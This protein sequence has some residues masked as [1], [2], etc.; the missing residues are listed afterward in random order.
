MSSV[1]DCIVSFVDG[2]VRLR[3]DAL[4]NPEIAAVA[5]AAAGGIDGV[6]SVRVNPVTGSLLVFY[7]PDRLS[8]ERLAA[9]ADEWSAFLPEENAVK[10]DGRAR[11]CGGVSALLGR[12]A[13]RL[14]DRALL[15]SL[16][17]SLVG[18]AA[19]MGTLHRVAGAAFALASVQHVAAH[20]RA[21]W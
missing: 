1:S 11:E 17:A 18:A 2:R 9:L 15:V 13:V 7:D 21:L 5:E 8:R 16:L 6:T 12:R 20:R 10:K 3:H 19:G 14:V 4:K